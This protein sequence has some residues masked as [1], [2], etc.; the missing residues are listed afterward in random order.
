MASF[1]I[2]ALQ[3]ALDDSV[4]ASKLELA[5]KQYT[6][7]TEK[8]R[9]KLECTKSLVAFKEEASGYQVDIFWLCISGTV[10]LVAL[11]FLAL[12]NPVQA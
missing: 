8:Y 5:N 10:L 4:P 6:E 7:L 2:A 11:L 9:D 3:K 12:M 1:K